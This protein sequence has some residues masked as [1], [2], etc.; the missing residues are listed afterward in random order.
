MFQEIQYEYRL[1]SLLNFP[2]GTILDFMTAFGCLHCHKAHLLCVTMGHIFQRNS[3]LNCISNTSLTVATRQS[4]SLVFD[5]FLTSFLQ[6]SDGFSLY[7]TNQNA[8]TVRS[9]V[10]NCKKANMA[11]D[12]SASPSSR[13]F[14]G[15][16]KRKLTR[17]L[18]KRCQK[19][20]KN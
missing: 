11:L 5:N 14:I 19:V 10:V 8:K 17:K 20:V 3:I 7:L 16:F 15:Q 4:F 6:L 9:G 13:I 18:I 12:N 1:F 2:R